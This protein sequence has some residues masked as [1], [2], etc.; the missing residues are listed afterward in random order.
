[1]FVIMSQSQCLRTCETPVYYLILRS[2]KILTGSIFISSKQLNFIIWQK[3]IFLCEWDNNFIVI[4]NNRKSFKLLKKHCNVNLNIL[5]FDWN[6]SFQTSINFVL[7]SFIF[8][9]DE[10]DKFLKKTIEKHYYSYFFLLNKVEILSVL[11]NDC[12]L[13]K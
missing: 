8:F 7:Y 5:D 13:K 9:S 6:L 11:K 10:Q 4:F 12:M 1:M 3:L 2:F